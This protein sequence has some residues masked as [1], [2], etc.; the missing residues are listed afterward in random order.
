[1]GVLKKILFYFIPMG[2]VVGVLMTVKSTGIVF[3]IAAAMAGA[4]ILIFNTIKTRKEWR[5]PV[6]E[7]I[8]RSLY[9]VA[10][11]SGVVAMFMQDGVVVSLIHK[12]SAE[13]AMMAV[14]LCS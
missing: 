12:V 7:I 1:M 9:V 13:V 4:G 14:F 3:H 6:I 11:I 5:V 10:C 8:F 2:V